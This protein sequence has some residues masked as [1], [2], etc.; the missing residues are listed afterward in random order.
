MN[1]TRREGEDGMNITRRTFTTAFPEVE[2]MYWLLI[3]ENERGR[4]ALDGEEEFKLYTYLRK[5]L[6]EDTA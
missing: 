4:I 1:I 2:P 6:D 5:H 3:I